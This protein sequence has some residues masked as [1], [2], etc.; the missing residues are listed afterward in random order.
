MSSLDQE[1]NNNNQKTNIKSTSSSFIENK[2]NE[3]KDKIEERSQKEQ[4]RDFK[5]TIKKTPTD[6]KLLRYMRIGRKIIMFFYAVFSLGF[7][8]ALFISL[9]HSV[10]L[11]P[12]AREIWNN[13]IVTMKASRLKS[14]VKRLRLLDY[15]LEE[16]SKDLWFKMRHG[17]RYS[18]YLIL[19][20]D[21]SK[22]WKRRMH[23]LKQQCR[24]QETTNIGRSFQQTVRGLSKLQTYQ[25]KSFYD[26][27]KNS[28]HLF[29]DV[30]QGL[31]ALK[32]EL[33]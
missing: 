24:L 33:R 12:K 16:K 28:G 19:W 15:D 1:K 7:V 5:K 14:C 13:K 3:N 10:N 25:E 4:K 9:Y 26:F 20:K 17:S 6:P 31:H 29:R 23:K 2:S 27:Y 21:F 11:P 32:E 8:I 18:R 30:R 22:N